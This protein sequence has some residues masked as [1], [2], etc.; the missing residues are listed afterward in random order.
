VTISKKTASFIR[1]LQLKKYRTQEQRFVVE[2]GKGVVELMGSDFEIDMVA[3]TPSFIEE[4]EPLLKSRA[5]DVR[6]STEARLIQLGSLQ[7]NMHALAVV[8]MKPNLPPTLDK[9]D[10]LVVLDALRDPG[11]L[12]TILRACD[13]YGLTHVVASEDTADLYN[14][15]VVI[16]SMGSFLRVRTFYTN[17]EQYLMNLNL[18]IYGM[19][20][21]GASVHDFTFDKPCCIVIGN[22]SHGISANLKPFITQSVTIPGYG[23]AESLNAAM[24]TTV[25]LD[26]LRRL[27]K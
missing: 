7:S 17:L 26:N 18:P 24:A 8:R 13:W 10:Y 1:S 5:T 21:E 23:K 14:P 3:A 4:H 22:E 2:G 9:I 27:E 25:V 12:G 15:K 16:S 11:N 19:F 6:V 20:L